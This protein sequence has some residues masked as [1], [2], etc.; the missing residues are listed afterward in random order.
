MSENSLIKKHKNVLFTKNTLRGEIH[1]R[2]LVRFPSKL[3]QIF[4]LISKNNNSIGKIYA[5]NS[6]D[7]T[8]VVVK[9]L[10]FFAGIDACANN[11]DFKTMYDEKLSYLV[12]KRLNLY[13]IGTIHTHLFDT[14]TEI[15][16]N[17]CKPNV[18]DIKYQF[19]KQM[20]NQNYI[21]I[22]CSIDSS[23]SSQFVN[24]N[25]M[26]NEDNKVVKG[27]T[28]VFNI[29]LK[30]NGKDYD[31]NL[32]AKHL[33]VSLID[34]QNSLQEINFENEDFLLDQNLDCMIY[35]FGKSVV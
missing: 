16:E 26:L 2:K 17:I 11:F 1:T 14:K 30:I 22:I 23:N 9:A 27:D 10:V 28:V 3:F 6:I 5:K 15:K 29:D 34:S 7:G 25:L 8:E 20:L 24:T 12:N 32:V 21:N 4:K 13:E 33:L 35:D 31:E 19:Y 18:T